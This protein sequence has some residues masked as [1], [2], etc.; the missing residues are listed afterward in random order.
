MRKYLLRITAVLTTA[1]LAVPAAGQATTSRPDGTHVYM[2]SDLDLPS[3]IVAPPTCQT[4][5]DVDRA[6]FLPIL[7]FA[8]NMVLQEGL[9]ALSRRE[10]AR[11]ES[12]SN[13]YGG[14]ANLTGLPDLPEQTAVAGGTPVKTPCMAVERRANNA[15]AS[16]FIFE[17]RA[18]DESA[19]MAR[20]V[21]ASIVT[22]PVVQA[23]RVNTI[24]TTV[25]LGFDA[26]VSEPCQGP[27][28]VLRRS[29]AIGSPSF[30]FRGLTAGT[31]I[32]ACTSPGQT[33]DCRKLGSASALMPRPMAGFPVTV[34]ATVSEVST[35]LQNAK[36]QNAIWER[37][38]ANLLTALN[39]VISGALE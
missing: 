22:S 15:L 27:G 13:S 8:A 24:N 28:C 29:Q 21:Y 18:I 26:I 19:F 12:Y 2:L 30:T 3:S 6:V 32:T 5:A 34:A 23:S 9:E 4:G 39:K 35:R 25:L 38:R 16:L 1:A 37:Q 17:L 31:P 7:L 11:L 20:P 36:I 14:R 10:A 33:G